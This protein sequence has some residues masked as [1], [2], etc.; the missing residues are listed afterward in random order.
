MYKTGSWTE[1][2]LASHFHETNRLLS[3]PLSS[4]L[5][6]PYHHQLDSEIENKIFKSFYFLCLSAACFLCYR[7]WGSALEFMVWLWSHVV[8]IRCW[9]IDSAPDTATVTNAATATF[10][11]SHPFFRFDFNSKRR[12]DAQLFRINLLSRWFEIT[13]C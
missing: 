2:I 7:S 4:S 6:T 1:P 5:S 9:I 12:E 8:T 10:L 3:F 11:K 13:F